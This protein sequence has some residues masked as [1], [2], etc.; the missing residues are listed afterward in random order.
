MLLAA[1]RFQF[2]DL[3]LHRA[4]R[5]LHRGEGL[6]HLR[7]AA[8]TLGK[9]RSFVALAIESLAVLQLQRRHLLVQRIRPSSDGRKLGG[10]T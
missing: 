5:F 10:K 8:F 7:L 3:V 9:S 2:G 1:L 6:Q 4:Q